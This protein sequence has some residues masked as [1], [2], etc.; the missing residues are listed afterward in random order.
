MRHTAG[1]LAGVG[2]IRYV[3]LC[4][5]AV[6]L[7]TRAGAEALCSVSKPASGLK[8]RHRRRCAASLQR[9][10]SEDMDSAISEWD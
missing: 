4:V 5:Y 7:Q 6:R 3:H 9:V 1:L 10:I 2:F 8:E